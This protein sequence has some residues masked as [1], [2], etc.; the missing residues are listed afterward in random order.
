MKGFF[1]LPA[2]LIL[3][4]GTLIFTDGVKGFWINAEDGFGADFP[5]PPTRIEAAMSL[6]SGYAYQSTK[7]FDKG[8]ALFAITVA[9]LPF[10]ITKEMQTEFIEASNA[11]FIEFMGQNPSI[12]KVEWE[13]F[14]NNRKRLRYAFDL[15]H[16]GIPLKGLGFWIMDTDRL[17]RVSVVYQQ[18]L[19]KNKAREVIS[20]LDSFVLLTVSEDASVKELKRLAEQGYAKAQYNMGNRYTNGQDVVKDYTLAV[21]WYRL[22]AA[23]GYANAQFKL[24]VMYAKGQGVTKNY[25]AAAKWYLR[26]FF[27]R[28]INLI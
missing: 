5:N 1:I 21:K 27:T 26:Y 17:I 8:G 7:S 25:M 10:N 12:A 11:G 28:F 19:S 16:D 18:S 23:Q 14:G 6:V 13:N 2:T 24:C 15:F 9:S 22:A 20:F 4:I 3:L